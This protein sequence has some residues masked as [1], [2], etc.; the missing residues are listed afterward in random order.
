MLTKGH[1]VRKETQLT[2]QGSIKI[3]VDVN[4]VYAYAPT[5]CHV[6]LF[7]TPWTVARQASLSMGSSRQGYWSGCHFFLQGIF[8]IQGWNPSLLC[9]LHLLYWQADSLPLSQLGNL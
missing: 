3:K 1:H 5:L 2:R 7:A 6:R 9:L 4:S 8:L